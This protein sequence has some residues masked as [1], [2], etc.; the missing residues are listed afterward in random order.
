MFELG[1]VRMLT[2]GT[3]N[4]GWFGHPATTTMYVLALVDAATFVGGW[5][6]GHF[7]DPQ[8]FVAAAYGHPELLILPGRLAMAA[9]AVLALWQTSR[10][11]ESQTSELTSLMR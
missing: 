8:A 5:I 10:R 9:F 1:A 11:K 6:T 4:P 7:A 3:L 2:G